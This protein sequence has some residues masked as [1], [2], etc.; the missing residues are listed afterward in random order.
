MDLDLILNIIMLILSVML[1]IVGLFPILYRLRMMAKYNV[2]FLDVEDPP[3]YQIVFWAVVI[4]F[5]I[6]GFIV[7]VI[8]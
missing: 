5:L 2:R 6:V 8:L 1:I 3:Q 7:W 4:P